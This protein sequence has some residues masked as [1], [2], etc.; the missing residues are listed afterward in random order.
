MKS[1][2]IGRDF[3]KRPIWQLDYAAFMSC[4][5]FKTKLC[6]PRHPFTKGKVE[7][8]IRF[9]K[10]NFLA[11]RSFENITKLNKQAL[12]WCADQ[13]S[14]YRKALNCVP[15]TQH[16]E[17]CLPQCTS[18]I[19]TNEIASYLCPR[20]KISFDGFVSYEGR[21]F[22]VPYW[23]TLRTC[24]INRDGEYIHIY[25]EDLTRE[26][27]V[28]L[29]TWSRKDRLCE[30]QYADTDTQPFELPSAPVTTTLRQLE[31]PKPN[32]RFARFDFEGK[33]CGND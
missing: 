26:L 23:Y 15:A 19:Q 7:R 10:D 28:H 1:V 5:G 18:I 9:V 31:P 22:G 11:G 16:S 24:R 13:S 32:E 27:A 29:V 30:D 3:E 2:V 8:L 25:S 12:L 4:V 33:V 21:R 6:K 17:K 20:R 14:R